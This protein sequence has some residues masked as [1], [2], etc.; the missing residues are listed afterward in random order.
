MEY[1]QSGP[2]LRSLYFRRESVST[3]LAQ[4]VHKVLVSLRLEANIISYYYLG[5]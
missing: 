4:P 5:N 2:V 3:L 1:T